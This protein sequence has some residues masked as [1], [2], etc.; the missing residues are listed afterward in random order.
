MRSSFSTALR[1]WE[2]VRWLKPE[3]VYGR[4]W[5]RLLRPKADARPAPQRRQ[6]TAAW[7]PPALRRASLI[8]PRLFRFLNLEG[9]LSEIGWDGSGRE[10]LWRYNQH[11]FEDLLSSGAAD[12]RDWH[13]ALL[14]DWL[15]QNPPANGAG[16]EPY[17]LSLRIVNWIKWA[18]AGAQLS[19]A[20]TESLAIQA[21]F[22]TQRLERHLLGN[23]LFVNAKALIFAGLYFDGPEAGMWRRIGFGILEREFS[24]QILAD[25]GQFERSPMYHAL[26]LE[27]V[28]DLINVA[29]TFESV[30]YDYQRAALAQW[31][32]TVPAMRRWL[33]ALSHPDGDISFFNDA[34]FG[35]AP[36]RDELE[37]YADRL[38]LGQGGTGVPL[39]W[40]AESGHAR[41]EQKD[42]LLLCDLAPIGPDYLPG[43]AHAD[44]LSFELSLF[45]A[46]VIVNSGTSVYGLSEERLR[47]RGT[48][49]HSTVTVGGRNS[50]DVWSGFRVG[51]RARP[52]GVSVF[53]DGARLIAEGRHDGYRS[54]PGRPVHC[55]RWDLSTGALRIEDRVSPGDHP[56]E[57]R[58]Y[59]HPDVKADQTGAA[60]G[61][62]L[63]PYG[64]QVHWRAEGGPIRIEDSTWHPEFGKTVPSQCLVLPL[65]GGAAS[66][67]LSWT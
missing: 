57:A 60:D 41:L 36:H 47:Q 66:L 3:Q 53:Q 64:K 5:F 8:G 14:A 29:R 45:G 7:K 18:L 23:H 6:Q 59:L 26:A 15:T 30:L 44:T 62:L 31:E 39:T 65:Q 25:G 56:A 42:A 28:L 21:R 55:R 61:A 58:F 38:G 52:F 9:D 16:W 33:A 10:K 11:Y 49:A 22:L 19:E 24:E 51:A 4:V 12:R 20:L 46:R 35:I 27:D 13:E 67:E 63:M 48:P 37:A 43:H 32:T 34:A 50:S 40:L 17:P 2:T 1:Y 54:L